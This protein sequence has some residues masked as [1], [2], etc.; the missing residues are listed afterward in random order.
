MLK[1]ETLD[2]KVMMSVMA[3]ED[4]PGRGQTWDIFF[5]SQLLRMATSYTLL[6][7]FG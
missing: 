6:H 1:I 4:Y 5:L 2:L 3:L 7:K